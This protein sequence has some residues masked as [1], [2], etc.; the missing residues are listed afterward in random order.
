MKLS[1]RIISMVCLPFLFSVVAC[2]NGETSNDENSSDE[3]VKENADNDFTGG[4]TVTLGNEEYYVVSNTVDSSETRSAYRAAQENTEF[5][6]ELVKA[7]SVA[8]AMDYATKYY[9]ENILL[10]R[11]AGRVT[12]PAGQTE[13]YSNAYNA[14][15]ANLPVGANISEYFKENTVS[16]KEDVSYEDRYLIL[17]KAYNQVGSCRV[18]WTSELNKEFENGKTLF[19]LL[20]D[21]SPTIIRKTIPEQYKISSFFQNKTNEVADY[22]LTT[23]GGYR[24]LTYADNSLYVYKGIYRA[25]TLC[26]QWDNDGTWKKADIALSAMYGNNTMTA[27]MKYSISYDISKEQYTYQITGASNLDSSERY[28]SEKSTFVF[29][30]TKQYTAESIVIPEDAEGLYSADATLTYD[31]NARTVPVEFILNDDGSVS[32]GQKVYEWAKH[33]R[34]YIVETKEDAEIFEVK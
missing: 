1:S 34:D 5:T 4:R 12:V 7:V 17:D 6:T 2:D 9:G 10:L 33:W 29:D 14:L 22:K 3:V 19:D 21:F 8:R 27:G 23:D 26:N 25:A 20:K 30:E 32:F 13:E 31:E 11:T 24:L 16:T 15:K 28:R 18:V